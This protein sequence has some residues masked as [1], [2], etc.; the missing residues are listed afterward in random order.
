MFKL[1][2]SVKDMQLGKKRLKSILTMVE[3]PYIK[4]EMANNAGRCLGHHGV[5]LI[6]GG[7]AFMTK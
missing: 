6:G 3:N 1:L 5:G 2:M 4:R 7:V